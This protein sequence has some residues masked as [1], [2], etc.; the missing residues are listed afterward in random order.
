MVERIVGRLDGNI[1]HVLTEVSKGAAPAALQDLATHAV[2]H[3]DGVQDEIRLAL[4]HTAIGV[5]DSQLCTFYQVSTF[6]D[7]VRAMDGHIG[8]L[9]H[10]LKDKRPWE[11]TFPPSPRA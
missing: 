5:P 11:D 1:R 7:L 2:L 9:Q 10:K 3:L 6:Q 8:Q 4:R